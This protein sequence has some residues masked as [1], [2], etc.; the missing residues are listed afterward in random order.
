MKNVKIWFGEEIQKKILANR[1][2]VRFAGLRSATPEEISA[3]KDWLRH[4]G[5]RFEHRTHF[6]NGEKLPYNGVLILNPKRK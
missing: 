3:T 5:I 1:T 6:I 4:G 2:K